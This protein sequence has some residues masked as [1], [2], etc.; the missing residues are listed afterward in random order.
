MNKAAIE[1]LVKR[2]QELW[3][4]PKEELFRF[5]GEPEADKLLNDLTDHPH[6]FVLAC[7]MDRQIKAEKAWLI[8]QRISKR[9]GGFSIRKL[10]VLSQ[11]DVYRIMKEPEPLHR[12]VNKMAEYFYSAVQRIM[13]N[14]AGDASRIWTDKPSSAELV[15]RFLQFDGVG[16]KIATM[17][18]NILARHFKIPLADYYSIDISPDVHVRRVFSRLGLIP[19]HATPEQVIYKARALY[20]DYPGI[21]DFTCWEIGRNWC[22]TL[23]PA[24]DSCYMKEL[25]PTANKSR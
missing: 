13:N 6:A 10:S 24:C 1:E 4:A 15:Y 7:I 5:T 8:P 11:E 2:G 3:H 25:C 19:A 20:P 12:F 14:Y 23:S 22:H 21:M 9:L 17:A 16:V 18:A